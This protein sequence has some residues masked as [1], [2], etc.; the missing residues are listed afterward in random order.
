MTEDFSVEDIV[1]GEY[2]T[3][4]DAAWRR[5]VREGVRQVRD[6]DGLPLSPDERAAAKPRPRATRCASQK[7]ISI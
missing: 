4:T 5:D 7:P 1:A 3:D 2:A 6:L